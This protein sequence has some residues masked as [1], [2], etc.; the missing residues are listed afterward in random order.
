MKGR[1]KEP[2][3]LKYKTSTKFHNLIIDSSGQVVKMSDIPSIPSVDEVGEQYAPQGSI[4]QVHNLYQTKPDENGCTSWTKEEPHDLVEPAENLES[5]Q[6][7]L[8]VR[9][10]KCYDGR[11]NLEIDSI[12]IQSEPLKKLLAGVMKGY[13]GLTMTLERIE[14]KKPF[15]AFVHRWSQLTDAR[16]KETDPTAKAHVDLLY[17]I[18]EDELHDTVSHKN[19]LLRN[20]VVT[21]DLLWTIF[22]PGETVYS[23]E[24]GHQRIYKF[25]FGDVNEYTKKFQIT[26]S[27]IDF[28]GT[29]FGYM[30][31]SLL[32][33]P[34]DGTK[35]ITSLPAFPL[36]CH[37]DFATVRS[38]MIAR[39]KL[40]LEHNG[41]HYKEY[42]G[43]GMAYYMDRN[44][45]Y[46]V[47]SRIIIDA[48]AYNTFS[49]GDAFK[50]HYTISGK[51]ADKHLLVATPILRGYSLKDKKWLEFFVDGLKDIEWNSRAFDALVLPDEDLALKQLIFAF[52]QAQSQSVEAFDDVIQGKGRG[53]VMLLSGPPGVGKTLT[54]E[55]VAEIMKV[56]LYVLSAGDLS[57]NAALLEEKMKDILRM[58]PKWGG[59]LLLDEADVFMEA[60]N[61]ND[62]DRNELVCV[63]LRLL[64]YYEVRAAVPSRLNPFGRTRLTRPRQG[65]LFLT[66]NRSDAIDPA[67]ESRIHVALRYPN[68]NKSTRRRIWTQLLGPE[69]SSAISDHELSEL[70]D[71]PLNGRQIKNVLKTASLLANHQGAKLDYPHIQL[72]LNLRPL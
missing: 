28:D 9:N 44:V 37:E 20:G 47:K 17:G 36:I 49:P 18:L 57:T 13:P 53:V 23:T 70:A 41:Y 1:N 51:L 55:S 56:P 2:V 68:L 62:L 40:W 38:D 31:T 3:Q 52:A 43:R 32:I 12:V 14:F 24:N 69:A 60:R 48:E 7:A 72:V 45:S 50:V 61:S 71:V 29:D 30:S 46:N 67:F 16:D 25:E 11:K 5:D 27:Y 54:A 19:D 59:V 64:E 42:E 66:S 10:V 34:F 35:P 33:P 58:V 26:G 21:F 4:S 6:F 15:K 8:L 39:G 22:E 65:I 63:F